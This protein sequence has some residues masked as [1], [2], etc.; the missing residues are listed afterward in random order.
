MQNLPLQRSF[1]VWDTTIM[2]FATLHGCPLVCVSREVTSQELQLRD[3][4]AVMCMQ[5][6]PRPESDL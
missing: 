5:V 3:S 2:A 4:S 1:P 6:D